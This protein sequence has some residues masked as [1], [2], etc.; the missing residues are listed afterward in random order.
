VS[1]PPRPSVVISRLYETPWNPATMTMRPRSSSSWIRTGRTSMMRAPECR[2]LVMMP[3]CDPVN[4]IASC[5]SSAIAIDRRAIAMR[6]PH[7]SNMSSSRRGGAGE[8]WRAR[9]MSSSVVSPIAETTTQTRLPARAVSTTRAA[10]RRSLV[11]SAT[12]DPPYFCTT[13]DM[14]SSE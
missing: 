12:D 10:T 1:E 9:P 14:I 13:I 5:P 4:E 6:S 2:S 7:D 3:D 11:M 8:I